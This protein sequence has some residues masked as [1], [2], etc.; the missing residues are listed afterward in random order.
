MN[1]PHMK[2]VSL[3]ILSLLLVI[4]T[5]GLVFAAIAIYRAGQ[6]EIGFTGT[7][8]KGDRDWTFTSNL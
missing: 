4:L 2:I 3:V 5:T 6:A 1:K 8:V 7:F